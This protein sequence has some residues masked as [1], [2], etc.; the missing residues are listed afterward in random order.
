MRYL[1]YKG[2]K[3]DVG[4]K[5]KVNTS[6]YGEQIMVVQFGGVT[7]LELYNHNLSIPIRV[8]MASVII[9]IV[10]PVEVQMPLNYSSGRTPPVV[11]DVGWVWYIVIM[12]GGLFF[13]DR[14]MIWIFATVYF[15]LWINGFLNGGK[16]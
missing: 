8:G 11:T 4:T 3:Y 10:E 2:K 13:D 7:G 9:E 16:K 15:I 5:V 6:W 1:E 14:W 12:F